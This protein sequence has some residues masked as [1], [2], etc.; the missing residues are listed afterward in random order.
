MSEQINM[1]CG[2]TE[3]CPLSPLLFDLILEPLTVSGK[4]TLSVVLHWQSQSIH[5]FRGT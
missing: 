5:I 3:D 1:W 4:V 2:T